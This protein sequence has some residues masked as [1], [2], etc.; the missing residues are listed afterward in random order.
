MAKQAAK[1]LVD[2]NKTALKII[3]YGLLISIVCIFAPIT[4]IS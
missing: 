1:K 3:D 4:H 2:Q